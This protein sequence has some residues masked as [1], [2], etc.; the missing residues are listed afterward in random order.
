M[1]STQL[2]KLTIAE[3]ATLLEARKVS[4]VE[5]LNSV[6]HRIETTE[7]SVHAYS[8]VTAEQAGLDARAA[9]EEIG[10]GGWRGPLHG[11]PIALKDLYDVSGVRTQAGSASF[12]GFIPKEDSFVA[13]KLRSA[14]AIL[15]GKTVTHEIAYGQNVPPTRNPWNRALYPGGS[16]AGSAVSVAI[17]STIAAMGTDTGG[18]IRLPATLNGIVGLKPTFGL[19]SKRGVV[20]LSATL[21]HCGPITKCVEDAALLLNVIAGYDPDDP[22]SLDIRTNS[23]DSDLRASLRGLRIG[24]CRTYFFSPTVIPEIVTATE[25][26]LAVFR[27]LGAQIVDV[28]IPALA[29]APAAG[30]VLVMAEASTFYKKWLRSKPDTFEAGTRRAL[31]VGELIFATDYLRAQQVR[32]ALIQAM[33]NA[34]RAHELDAVVGPTEPLVA[35]PLEDVAANL[36]DGE[37]GEAKSPPTGGLA[38]LVS[39]TIPFNLTGQPA[40]SLPSGFTRDGLP[41]GLQIAGRPLGDGTVLRL[42]YAFERATEW[43]LRSPN[44]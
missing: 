14:G 24:V 1:G 26:A 28:E 33:Q 39:H 19:V 6:L 25:K 34:F 20:P 5:L 36:N 32:R 29:S 27:S 41:I 2:F 21:D 43:H 7:P 44:L 13:A 37:A 31:Q 11:I 38:A 40:I 16:S 30:L 23:F 22:T 9:D 4:P 18:S 15:I 3:A 8:L 42:G 10:R 17:D 12:A 35:I